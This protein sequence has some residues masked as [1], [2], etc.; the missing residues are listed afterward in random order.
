MKKI[1]AMIVDDSATVRLALKQALEASHDIEVL[2]TA[3]DPLFAL[4]KMNRRWPDVVVLDLEMPRMDG[5]AF[6]KR[7]MEERPT[8][9]VICSSLTARGTETA[10][11]ALAAGAV[12]VFC[13]EDLGLGG[14][15]AVTATALVQAV[16]AAAGARVRGAPTAPLAPVA[17]RAFAP[18]LSVTTEHVVAIGTSTGGTQA[19]EFVLPQ[20]PR[21]CPGVVVV[22]HMPPKFTTAFAERLGKLSA[23]EVLEANGGERVLPGRVLIAPGGRH[24]VVRR[25]GAYYVADVLDAPPVNRHRPSVDVLFRSVAKAAG[26]NAVGF[27]LTGMGDDG[28]RGLLEMRQAGARTYAQDEASSVVFGMPKEAI[29]LGAAESVVGLER[30]PRLIAT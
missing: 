14:T 16:R 23:V 3:M 25:E 20:L 12:A 21:T 7:L 11:Q 2:D 24:L 28:A 26:R 4:T 15:G 18:Q 17:V 19:L 1:G 22:Q 8:P 30:V 29:A 9:V 13:K 5:L 6:L 27:L 10:M